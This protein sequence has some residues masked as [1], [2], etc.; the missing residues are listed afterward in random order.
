MQF[1]KNAIIWNIS[2]LKHFGYNIHNTCMNI[3]DKKEIVLLVSEEAVKTS[4][5]QIY[6]K[7]YYLLHL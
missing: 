2:C 7:I 1:L 4:V 3:T 5:S 6:S